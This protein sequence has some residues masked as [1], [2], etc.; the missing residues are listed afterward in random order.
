MEGISQLTG[1]RSGS[2]RGPPT[3]PIQW[4]SHK[5]VACCGQMNADLVRTPGENSRFQNASSIKP[6][7]H[8][9]SGTRFFSSGRSSVNRSQGMVR[10]RANGDIH[11]ELTLSRS[12]RGERAI[13]LDDF[14]LLKGLAD[15]RPGS[16]A[17]C[18]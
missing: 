8:P 15:R 7:Q 17:E 16:R 13:D 5:R 2:V 9:D 1:A 3:H 4:I 6:L 11:L 14:P 12:S 18:A 10:Q